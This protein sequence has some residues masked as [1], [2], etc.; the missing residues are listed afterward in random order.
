MASSLASQS[1]HLLVILI[2]NFPSP[3]LRNCYENIMGAEDNCTKS[4]SNSFLIPFSLTQI[5][6]LSTTNIRLST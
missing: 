3:P 6:Q 1:L 5:F 2:S 4:F